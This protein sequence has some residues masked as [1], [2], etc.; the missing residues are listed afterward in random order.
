VREAPEERESTRIAARQEHHRP[1][2]GEAKAELEAPLTFARDSL[3]EVVVKL[4][5]ELTANKDAA[6]TGRFPIRWGK[7]ELSAPVRFHL[8]RSKV[9]AD[10]EKTPSIT[11]R[12]SRVALI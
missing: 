7:H 4:L 3:K 6:A 12:S 2:T 1:Y 9:P 5:I 10:S 8:A 11:R